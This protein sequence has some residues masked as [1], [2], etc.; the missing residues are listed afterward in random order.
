MF[1]HDYL[2]DKINRYS[3]YGNIKLLLNNLINDE[4]SL[5]YTYKNANEHLTLLTNNNKN[6]YIKLEQYDIDK[7]FDDMDDFCDGI[8]NLA[9]DIENI[10]NIID[11]FKYSTNEHNSAIFTHIYDLYIILNTL[12]NDMINISNA[13]ENLENYMVLV[14]SKL[15]VAGV[16]VEIVIQF[17]EARLVDI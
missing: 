9:T 8:S 13:I 14:R 15:P 7:L 5:S 4:I 6:N 1:S 16:V 3:Q 17:A 2:L 11:N 12:S 10:E